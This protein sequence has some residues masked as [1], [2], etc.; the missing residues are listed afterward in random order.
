[1][2]LNGKT[3]LVTGASRGIGRA[4][5]KA[6]VSEGAS[7]MICGRSELALRSAYHEISQYG[8]IEYIRADISDRCDVKRLA[9]IIDGKWKRL[10]ILVNNA[11]ILGVRAPILDYPEDVWEEVI[12][13]NLNAQFFITKSVL[14]LILKSQNGS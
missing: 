6:Y 7:V 4:V 14:P 3:A 12:R 5:A 11:S 2:K 9:D 1:M 10:N 13:I 8:E